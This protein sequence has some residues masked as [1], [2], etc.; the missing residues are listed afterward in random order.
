MRGEVVDGVA[1]MLFADRDSSALAAELLRERGLMLEPPP[2]CPE[3]G[4]R[5]QRARNELLFFIFWMGRAA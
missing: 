1:T 4:L 2:Q 3:I 5:I